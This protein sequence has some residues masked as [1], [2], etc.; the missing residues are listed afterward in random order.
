MGKRV[1]IHFLIIMLLASA[2]FNDKSGVVCSGG[3]TWDGALRSCVKG[4]AALEG[5][6]NH[7][8]NVGPDQVEAAYEDTPYAFTLSTGSDQDNNPITYAIATAPANGTL[9]DCMDLSGSSAL[10]DLS[11]TY[12]SSDDYNGS[13]TFSYMASDGQ[14]DS[15][16]LAT[17]VVTVIA[18]DDPP[19]FTGPTPSVTMEESA[20]TPPTYESVFFYPAEGGSSDEDTQGLSISLESSDVTVVDPTEI[21]ISYDATPIGT[22][23]GPAD[24]IDITD[25]TADAELLKI[26]LD[27]KPVDFANGTVTLTV[28]LNDGTNITSD[29]IT[30]TV[31]E[32][33]NEPYIINFPT[34]STATEGTPIS[35]GSWFADEG[36]G[37]DGAAGDEEDQDLTVQITSQSSDFTDATDISINGGS[38]TGVVV[39]TG[40]GDDAKDDPFGVVISPLT[41]PDANGTYTFDL[42]ITDGVETYNGSFDVV[43]TAVNDVPLICDHSGGA[44][45]GEPSTCAAISDPTSVAEDTGIGGYE[46]LVDEGGDSFED[47]QELTVKVESQNTTIIADSDI[48]IAWGAATAVGGTDL[49]LADGTADASDTPIAIY[50]TP[51]A[52]VNTALSGPVPLKITVTDDEG[53]STTGTVNIEIAAVNDTPTFTP[54]ADYATDGIVANEGGYIYNVGFTIDEG[55]GSDEDLQSL[56]LTLASSNTQLFPASNLDTTFYDM[57][58]AL[59]GDMTPMD[60]NDSVNDASDTGKKVVLTLQPDA[61]YVGSSTIT[62]TVDDQNGGVN[63]YS[64]DVEVRAISAVHNGWEN[65]KSLGSA[66]DSE[67]NTIATAYVELEW[68]E[69]A[70]YGGTPSAYNIY[71]AEGP[72]LTDFNFATPIAT[73]LAAEVSTTGSYTDGTVTDGTMYWY[74]VAPVDNNS[75]PAYTMPQGLDSIIRVVVPPTNM[76]LVHR[77]IGNKEMCTMMGET[78]DRTQNY[79]CPYY[80]PEDI[81]DGTDH[82]FDLTT[83]VVVDQ[84]EAG[85]NYAKAGSGECTDGANPEGCIAIGPPIGTANYSASAGSLY[86]DRAAGECHI[87]NGTAWE[88]LN[89]TEYN[90]GTMTTGMVDNGTIDWGDT[91]FNQAHLP[92]LNRVSQSQASSFCA[93]GNDDFTL[94]N[95]P[96]ASTYR[97]QL[98]KRMHQIIA[99]AWPTATISVSATYEGGAN[100]DTTFYCNTNLGDGLTYTSDQVPP[101]ELI[102]TLPATDASTV[103][104]VRTGSTA[105]SACKSRYG[106]QDMIGNVKEWSIEQ[107]TCTGAPPGGSCSNPVPVDGSSAN[108]FES[109]AAIDSG[110]TELFYEFDGYSGPCADDVASDED[111]DDGHM[112]NIPWSLLSA[113]SPDTTK[114]YFPVGLPGDS[115]ASLNHSPVQ[116]AL[117]DLTSSSLDNGDYLFIGANGISLTQLDDG[118]GADTGSDVAGVTFGGSYLTESL[119][120]G[121]A[122]RWYLK[123]EATSKDGAPDL[124]ANP[125]PVASQTGPQ[126][127]T[128][129]R[130]VAPVGYQK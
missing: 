63:T 52:N 116:N 114:I 73:V 11:C 87:Y 68:N 37:L 113:L 97:R 125:T 67:A 23:G 111:C 53:G 92:P 75:T 103:K 4:T 105:T 77:W 65:V 71:R 86:W 16:S 96:N 88:N 95:D 62:L 3:Q 107:F 44:F 127:D 45:T 129:F 100:L 66:T 5:T 89:T 64:F 117:T 42:E 21:L 61:H 13:D 80:G 2:C 32:L 57:S 25:S 123:L 122:G 109:T 41:K 82:Y 93:D 47:S 51:Q 14:D 99:T 1:H 35:V 17:V 30:I 40:V 6:P 55:G 20:P 70:M 112:A 54:D 28:R 7:M 101:S 50:V 79:R 9:A 39:N 121:A 78:P 56:V 69:M 24:Y 81:L 10:D 58:T 46:F 12:T 118:A 91:V 27:I 106:I 72:D 43:I 38:Y 130:C 19:E 22:S 110:G 120:S 18:V 74:V 15:I 8:P 128:G 102:D 36:G 60:W 59:T 29:T 108:A 49:A 84:F 94:T 115:D 48:F 90:G 31:D 33:D 98:P 34:P 104:M 124:V 85:C 119:S 26:K 76:A 126:D 83:D